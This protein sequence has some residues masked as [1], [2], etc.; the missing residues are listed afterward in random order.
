[1]C[2]YV[3]IVVIKVHGLSSFNESVTTPTNCFEVLFSE[4]CYGCIF[5][6]DLE[7]TF[8]VLKV[9][10]CQAIDASHSMINQG[11]SS[12]YQVM[13]MLLLMFDKAISG[14]VKIS[15]RCMPLSVSTIY[16]ILSLVCSQAIVLG[17]CARLF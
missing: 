6:Y 1:M 5:S 16:C 12:S 17:E 11:V 2:I 14:I 9:Q 13:G 3:Y 4:E 7:E 10:V 15:I 8:D